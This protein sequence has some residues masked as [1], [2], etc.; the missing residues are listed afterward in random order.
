MKAIYTLI[1]A[2]VVTTLVGCKPKIEAPEPSMGDVDASRY[3]SIGTNNTSGFSND[4]LTFSGQSNSYA[5]ILAEQFNAVTSIEFKQ[6]FVSAG[7]VGFNLNNQSPLKLGYKTDCKGVTS[8]SPV[9][10][11]GSGDVSQLMNQY[12][13]YGPFNNFG[14][15]GMS[16]L[17][18]NNSGYGNPANGTGNF[19]P[20]FARFTSNEA[21]ASVLSDAVARNP[22]FFTLMLGDD[23][24]LAFAKSGGTNSGIP[25]AN[26]AAGVGFSGSLEE[27]I[28]ALTA[29]GAK[30]AIANIPDV[31]EYPY[32]TT[33][34]YNGLNLDAA[35]AVTV[36][37]IFNPIGLSFTE[38]ENPFT[39]EDPSEPFGVRKMV[40]GELVLLS[41]P[42]DS[43]KCNGM[44]SVN[45]FRDEFVLTLDE[46]DE[47][48]AAILEY[49]TI[50][51]NLSQTYGLATADMKSLI[52]KLKTG[53]VYN[54]VSMSSSF[55]TGGAYS[56]DGIQL[57]PNGQALLANTFIEAINGV[58]NAKIN[59][60][61]PLKY[62]GI[63]FP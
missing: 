34:P 27:I 62:P 58:F 49:N 56:L 7:S 51:I 14:V 45:P 39:V 54:G 24:I 5:A 23:D 52:H 31:K 21:N 22:T 20:Y 37:Q 44:G 18:V 30:G 2:L 36:N 63:I 48:N 28:M 35:S 11:A 60:A 46:V 29:N 16:V 42:L 17:S 9:R 15:T 61:N 8:L 25:V 53:T 33:I 57:N 59:Y 12:A 10:V 32:F 43:V 38:G 50:I 41:V 40:P 55:V 1:S 19:N 6:P 26:G 4:G 3:I 13:S 47:I